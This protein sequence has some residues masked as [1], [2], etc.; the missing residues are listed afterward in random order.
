MKKGAKVHAGGSP[1]KD[2]GER[3]YQ[4]TLLTNIKPDMLCYR[5]EIFGPVVTCIKCVLMLMIIL[6]IVSFT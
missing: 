4:P 6:E 2:L 3:W 5:E 1:A